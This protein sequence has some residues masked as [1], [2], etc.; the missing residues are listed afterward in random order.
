VC[1]HHPARRSILFLEKWILEILCQKKNPK[2][3]AG[4]M[5][6]ERNDI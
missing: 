5:Y 1:H 2:H 6:E 4:Y 3:V